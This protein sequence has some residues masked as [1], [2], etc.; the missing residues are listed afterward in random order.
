MERVRL[1]G[2]CRTCVTGM[3]LP[4]FA[5]A[6]AGIF[7]EQGIELEFVGCERAADYSLSG[8]TT[9]PKAVAAGH[10]DFA[11]S[12]VAYLLAA[13]TEL[14]GQ[15]PVRF[16]A[17]SHQ[18]NPIT[19]IVR[20]DSDLEEPGDLPGR[21]AARWSIPWFTDEYAGALAHMGFGKPQIVDLSENID[22]ALASGD[23][24]VMPTWMEM[25]LYHR[26][27]EFQIRTIPL[28]ID[29]YTTGL[30]A[31]DR[32]PLDVVTRVRDAYAA[33]FDL[34]SERPELGIA[35]FMRQYPDVTE[36]HIRRNWAL[37]EPYAW[38]RVS[39]GS[40]DAAR[41]RTTIHY[42]AAT[43]RLSIVPGQ[44]FYRPELVS[45]QLVGSAA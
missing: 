8:F 35:G 10:A 15:L 19:A 32:M 34:C 44:R 4:V 41:W 21:R 36:A 17:V 25:T 40:M 31:A 20:A 26:K 24:D 30:I 38:D 13:Q 6:E 23:I 12:G 14:G 5:A 29:V 39:P 43:H 11:L 18:R 45:E 27:P 2:W 22:E 33:G 37:F 28:D 42:T 7:A 9:R 3:H 16:V 1:M